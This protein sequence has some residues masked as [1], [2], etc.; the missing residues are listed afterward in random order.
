MRRVLASRADKSTSQGLVV[1][2]Q[3][4]AGMFIE[5]VC[6]GLSEKYVFVQGGSTAPCPCH[7]KPC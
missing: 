4:T 1:L 5:A 7:R 3:S 2:T 6:L